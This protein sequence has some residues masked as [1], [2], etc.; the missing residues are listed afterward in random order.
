MLSTM[1]GSEKFLDTLQHANVLNDEGLK[2]VQEDMEKFD[3]E[4][5]DELKGMAVI[6]I[7]VYGYNHMTTPGRYAH[8]PWE[9]KRYH[10]QKESGTVFFLHKDG[11]FKPVSG[12][13]ASMALYDEAKSLGLPDIPKLNPAISGHLISFEALLGSVPE[14]MREVLEK[15]EYDGSTGCYNRPGVTKLRAW[16]DRE[17]MTILGYL[18]CDMKRV[19]VKNDEGEDIWLD[20]PVTAL[21]IGFGRFEPRQEGSSQTTAFFHV[22]DNSPEFKPDVSWNWH[23]QDTSRWL[24]A[25]AIAI[26]YRKDEKTGEESI[27]ISSHH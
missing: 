23:L 25:G 26:N 11:D 16:Y 27:D 22:S 21:G 7:S 24:Y 18:Q 9:A 14:Y 8:D 10:K 17:I 6:D 19:R 1:T 20:S 13:E 3:R 12:E 5:F 2:R 15:K 4:Y